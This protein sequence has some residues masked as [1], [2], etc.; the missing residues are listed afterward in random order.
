MPGS[1]PGSGPGSGP[2]RCGQ[3][4]G[5]RCRSRGCHW[6][7]PRICGTIEPAEP[8]GL[9]LGEQLHVVPSLGAGHH[10]AAGH[11]DDVQ[12]IVPPA[13]RPPGIR[14]TA[15]MFHQAGSRAA[16][17]HHYPSQPEPIPCFVPRFY[18]HPQFRMRLPCLPYL[19]RSDQR[20]FDPASVLLLLQRGCDFQWVGGGS[21]VLVYGLV[22][23]GPRAGGFAEH[24]VDRGSVP[25]SIRVRSQAFFVGLS[26][27]VV[28]RPVAPTA[29]LC[30]LLR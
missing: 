19:R 6:A 4:P 5:Q 23:D 16:A 15:E 26:G 2:G 28:T 11:G 25:S 12:Q 27:L 1:S 17:H 9:A 22:V 20:G 24:C 18:Q 14:Q 30:E 7:T 29:S 13:L 3:T 8:F 21:G 10:A